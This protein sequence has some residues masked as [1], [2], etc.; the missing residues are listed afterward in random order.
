MEPNIAHRPITQTILAS[1]LASC[2]ACA[3]PAL[4]QSATGPEAIA[5]WSEICKIDS[6]IFLKPNPPGMAL[7]LEQEAI[8]AKMLD[9]AGKCREFRTRYPDERV[10]ASAWDME[11]NLLKSLVGAGYAPATQPLQELEAAAKANPKAP[12]STRFRLREEDLRRAAKQAGQDPESAAAL[13]QRARQLQREFPN[14][15]L[16]FHLFL[17]LAELSAPEKARTLLKEILASSAEGGVK[18]LA[19]NMLK[20]L[21]AVGKPLDIKFTAVDG[22]EV[23]LANMRGKVVLVDFWATWCSPCVAEI[24]HVKAAYEKFHGQGFEVVG[25]SFDKQNDK[26]KLMKFTVE[27]GM[28]WPQYFDGKGWKNDF[29]QTFGIGAIPVMWLVDKQ[30][31]L[32]ELNARS[33]LEEMVAKLLAE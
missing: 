2:L 24:P 30:G 31:N 22:R 26:E 33:K 1:M 13:E 5:A 4:A 23:D 8:C 6:P 17:R 9:R 16:G 32:R 18:K 7:T 15:V 20:K 11:L 25:I 14:A 27:R 3:A 19:G 29:G 12:E 21:D 10:T 28:P